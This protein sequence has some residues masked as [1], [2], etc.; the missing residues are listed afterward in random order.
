MVRKRRLAEVGAGSGRDEEKPFAS[1][2]PQRG[3]GADD[4]NLSGHSRKQLPSFVEGLPMPE[5][6]LRNHLSVSGQFFFEGFAGSC[7]MTMGILMARVPAV[8]PFD[9]MYGP[10]YDLLAQEMIFRQLILLKIIAYLWFGTPCRSFSFARIPELRSAAF[11]L[12][13]PFLKAHQ[14][15]IVDAGNA[16]VA[17]TARMVWH[18]LGE[19]CYFTVENPFPSWIWMQPEFLRIVNEPRR[20]CALTLTTFQSFDAPW[21]KSQV[22]FIIAQCY[23]RW[24]SVRPT[25]NPW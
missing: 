11:I 2:V 5:F 9:N 7:R 21:Y 10:E 13:K 15:E 19:A 6:L 1:L 16:L 20:R 12:G 22:L 17:Y 24:T 3:L 8:M 4:E 14:Q 25:S 18:C 23:M